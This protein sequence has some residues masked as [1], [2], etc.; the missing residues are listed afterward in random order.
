VTAAVA[1]INSQAL[2]HNLDRARAAAPG[3]RIL[4]VIKANAYGHGLVSVA[5]GLSG[6]DGFA[7]A[8]LEEAVE[9]RAAGIQ[10]PIVVLAGFCTAAQ[11][12][13]AVQQRLDMVVHTEEQVCLLESEAYSDPLSV[14]LKIDT[15]MGRLGVAPGAVR[16]VLERL[17]AA[18]TVAPRIRLMTHLACAEDQA[19]DVTR[20]QLACFAQAIGSWPGDVSIANSAAILR[21]PGALAAGSPVHYGGENWVRPGLMLYGASPVPGLSAAD[22]G[23]RPVMSFE[24]RLIAIRSVRR[25]DRIG[26]GGVWQ[27][28]S[29]GLV[30]IAA[31][32]Y[33]DGYPR[34]LGNGTPVKVNGVRVPLAGRVSMDLLAVDL[35]GCPGAR[36]GN[37]VILWGEDPGS[38][39]IAQLAGT[40]PYELMAGVTQRVGRVIR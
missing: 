5:Q 9:L 13:I 27:A 21:C 40:I 30:G 10:H 11:A 15:G 31:A 16:E 25:G 18:G 26:Y 17:G 6:A 3:C 29:D 36:I 34:R 38:D 20:R 4:A 2:H 32:G 39:E 14:W 24:T 28:D 33:A 8:R 7:V 22:F 19:S 1:V 37:R 23:L 35:T 12:R